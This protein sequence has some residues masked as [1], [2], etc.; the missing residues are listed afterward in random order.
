MPED[1]ALVRR[2]CKAIFEARRPNSSISYAEYLVGRPSAADKIGKEA[3]EV[4]S[5]IEALGLHV[6]DLN[7]YTPKRRLRMSRAGPRMRAQG[8]VTQEVRNTP[9]RLAQQVTRKKRTS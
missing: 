1:T 5:A 6:V 9:Q 7:L 2:I 4:L 3:N 8:K